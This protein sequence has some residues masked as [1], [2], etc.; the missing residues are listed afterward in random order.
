MKTLLLILFFL[1]SFASSYGQQIVWDPVVMSTLVLQHSEQQEK[2]KDINASESRILA[3][4]VY[5]SG[6]M[7]EIRGLHEKMHRRLTTVSSLIVDS[8]ELIYAAQVAGDV[9]TYQGQMITYASE[10]PALL[11][12]AYQAEKALVDRTASLMHY[13]Y[14]S[15]I[16]GEINMLDNRQRHQIMEHVIMELR[17]MRGLAYVVARKMRFARRAGVLTSLNPFAVPFPDQ[18]AAIITELLADI[19]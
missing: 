12:I 4:Q 14:S 10:N 16:G 15:L 17:T 2:L 6:K 5:I 3:A 19:N 7:E 1:G 8:R 13:L 9:A 18:D 11:L